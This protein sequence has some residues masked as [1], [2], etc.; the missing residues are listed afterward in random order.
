MPA[1]MFVSQST[2]R[3]VV[4]GN[5]APHSEPGWLSVCWGAGRHGAAARSC[6]PCG[7]GRSSAAL[8]CAASASQHR[9]VNENLIVNE[10]SPNPRGVHGVWR[11]PVKPRDRLVLL[12]LVFSGVCLMAW[13]QVRLLSH[14][15]L[16]MIQKGS[17]EK[18]GWE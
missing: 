14:V 4:T 3:R 13:L 1:R 8:H 7:S 9:C 11:I 2:E 5:A 6:Q 12:G 15:P 18:H 10:K 16:S 17:H